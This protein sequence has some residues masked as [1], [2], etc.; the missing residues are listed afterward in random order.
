MK[1]FYSLASY[2]CYTKISFAAVYPAIL[3]S[4]QLCSSI[5]S[6]TTVCPAMIQSIQLC[7]NLSSYDVI[8]PAMIQSIQLW[9]SLPSYATVLCYSLPSYATVYPFMIQS[10]QLYHQSTQLWYSLPSYT[11]GYPAIPQ[12]IQLYHSLSSCATTQ[13]GETNFNTTYHFYVCENSESLR[14]FPAK[15]FILRL[16]RPKLFPRTL[17][18]YLRKKYQ[19]TLLHRNG[20]KW[21]GRAISLR[22]EKKISD[23][24]TSKPFVRDSLEFI[25]TT[26]TL[27]DHSSENR[28]L[29]LPLLC[30]DW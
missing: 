26:E 30:G 29:L 2:V 22:K 15:I 3:W 4:I 13:D 25:F 17:R 23:M 24:Q 6:Y 8:Y 9:Y 7:Y 16:F 18:Y 20:S 19:K 1:L 10:I 5:S 27:L 14:I 28:L 21:P 12:A 11:T